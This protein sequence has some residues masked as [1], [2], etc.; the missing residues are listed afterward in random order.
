V[1][2]ACWTEEIFGPVLAVR[3]FTTE[4]E[5]VAMTNDTPY[6]LA[7]AVMSAD[8]ERCARIA[9]RLESGLVWKNC[10]QPL[11]TSTP[12]GGKKQSGFGRE[13]GEAGLDEYVHNK[14]V[15]GT[16]T[17]TNWGWYA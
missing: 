11:F 13:M 14:T 16:A 7:N 17:K 6:G 10:S 8:E 9:T 4:D 1:D 3:T 12:F 5:A 2:A 15:I